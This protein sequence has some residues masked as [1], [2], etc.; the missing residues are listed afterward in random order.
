MAAFCC[1]LLG[2]YLLALATPVLQAT[3]A[4]A[5]LADAVIVELC[6]ADGVRQVALDPS[7]QP[8]TPAP[9]GQHAGHDCAACTTG[10]PHHGLCPP[11]GFT[12]AGA[13]PALRS[14]PPVGPAHAAGPPT[15][16]APLPARGP[17][18]L[19]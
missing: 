6:S 9:L 7:G 13:W 15:A 11:R 12:L 4:H 3:L 17:P 16:R 10:C 19:S 5:A 8:V 18:G 1:W 14:P 2:L